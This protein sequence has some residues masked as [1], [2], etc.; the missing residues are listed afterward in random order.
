[1]STRVVDDIAALIQE[2]GGLSVAADVL[3]VSPARLGNWRKR[4]QIPPKLYFG[5]AAKLAKQEIRAPRSLWG[6][7]EDSSHSLLQEGERP[8]APS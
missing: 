6:F 1:M 7:R 8:P 2:L 4:G 5:H 3:G